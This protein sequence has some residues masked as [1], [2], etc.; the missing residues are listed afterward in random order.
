MKFNSAKLNLSV[1]LIVFATWAFAEPD[2]STTRNSGKQETPGQ[3]QTATDKPID[4]TGTG[5]PGKPAPKAAGISPETFVP[6]ENISQD[7]SVS[8]PVDI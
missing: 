8:F 7:L 6:T 4:R 5:Q 3:E 2:N 1:A